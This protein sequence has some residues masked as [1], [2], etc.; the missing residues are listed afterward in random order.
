MALV[1]DLSSRS[2]GELTL[3]D[4][5]YCHL[6][7]RGWE[8]IRGGSVFTTLESVELEMRQARGTQ[9]TSRYLPLLA[10]FSLIEQLGDCYSNKNLKRHPDRGGGVEKGLYYF[11]RHAA[12][13]AEV[14]ALYAL[15]NGLVHAG[16]LTSVD[17]GSE[18]R[19]IF[20]YDHDMAQAIAPAP[21][22]WDGQVSTV[23][24]RKVTRVNPRVFT[25]QVSSGIFKVRDLFFEDREKL[26]VE[27]PKGYI[28]M[29]HLLWSLP[30]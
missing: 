3:D 16:S 13:S 17:Q 20:R 4:V 29:N 6:S 19:Y 9:I 12:M 23:T 28:L 7:R 24:R 18:K 1:R 21:E 2:L 25:D 11:C 27:A 8:P 10:A 26:K 30:A 15:R 22:D 5:V 14:K